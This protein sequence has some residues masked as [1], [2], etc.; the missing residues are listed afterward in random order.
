[1]QVYLF[2]ILCV[3]TGAYFLMRNLSF[4]INEEQLRSYLNLSPS[5]RF[6]VEKYGFEK[7]VAMAKSIYL[8]ISCV[9]ALAVM[10]L[11]LWSLYVIAN[12]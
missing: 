2:P 4:L 1:M 3:V 8:P 9:I 7:T 5:G 12:A 11:G 6:W 10:G